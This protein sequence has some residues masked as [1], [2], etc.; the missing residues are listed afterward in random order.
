V[1][2]PGDEDTTQIDRELIANELERTAKLA[3]RLN[4]IELATEIGYIV[5]K[6][7]KT[8]ESGSNGGN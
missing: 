8:E 6:I 1:P 3:G 4:Q 7:R 5:S 2:E